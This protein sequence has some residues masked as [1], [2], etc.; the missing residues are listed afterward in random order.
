[1][2]GQMT[3]LQSLPSSR[4]ALFFPCLVSLSVTASLPPVYISLWPFQP[5]LFFLPL[6]LHI[7]TESRTYDES[8]NKLKRT[9]ITD[10][11]LSYR[12]LKRPNGRDS[13]IIGDIQRGPNEKKGLN[14]TH[15]S[16]LVGHSHHEEGRGG[17]P[18]DWREGCWVVGYWGLGW[19][20]EFFPLFLVEGRVEVSLE[21]ETR[22][23]GGAHVGAG[24]TTCP[25][26]VQTF[27]HSN[28]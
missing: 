14:K 6:S 13:A 28:I 5:A 22:S 26:P 10:T 2:S 4:F 8:D 24:A 16:P 3:S 20:G 9:E 7:L 21:V 19:W 25:C 12:L 17:E 11:P 1:M 15:S 27:K 23:G 18:S